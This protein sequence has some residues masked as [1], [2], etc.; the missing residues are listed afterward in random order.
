V[1]PY[2][3]SVRARS[4]DDRAILVRDLATGMVEEH[5]EVRIGPSTLRKHAQPNED[6]AIV[7]IEADE[8]TIVR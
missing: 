2:Q 3:I 1:P 7:F 5:E 6:F 4:M 8:V